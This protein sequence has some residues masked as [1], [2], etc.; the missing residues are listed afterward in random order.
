MV[1]LIIIGTSHIAKESI[2]Q[3]RRVIEDV[4][5]AIV[6]IELDTGRAHALLSKKE[7]KLRWQ[8]I[9]NIG[10]KGFLFS[11]IGAYVERKLGEK[12]GTAP[13]SEMKAAMFAA[14]K[15]G[16]RVALIDQDISI[17]L[18]RFSQVLSWS[19]KLKLVW[20]LL[21][22]MLGFGQ[23]ITF[24]LA[25]VPEKETIKKLT[26]EVKKKYPNIYKVLVTERNQFMAKNLSKLL[27]QTPQATI[28]AVV[29]AGHED[30]IK[31][32]VERFTKNLNTPTP[33]IHS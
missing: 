20:E 18:K 3:V 33:T 32:L 17:T 5:P 22:G 9:R 1:N 24:D 14:K 16:A 7:R 13:G 31:Q 15:I 8:D 26:K 2:A 27:Q 30:E 29:G 11:L 21:S 28:V 4:K 19:E 10:L 6:A 23:K 12:V 25:K